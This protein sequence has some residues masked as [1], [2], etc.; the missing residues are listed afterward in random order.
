MH[1][2]EQMMHYGSENLLQT[3]NK[4]RGIAGQLMGQEMGLLCLNFFT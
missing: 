1:Q 3:E 4:Y 2:R